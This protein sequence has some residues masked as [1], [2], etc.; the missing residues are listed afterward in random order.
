[1]W[2]INAISSDLA[3]G[4]G[5]EHCKDY[6]AEMLERDILLSCIKMMANVFAAGDS[7]MHAKC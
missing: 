5:C 2:S 1:M 6:L 4:L 3:S 7:M